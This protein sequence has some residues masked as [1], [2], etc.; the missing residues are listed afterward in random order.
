MH[1]GCQLTQKTRWHRSLKSFENSK[2]RLNQQGHTT[3]STPLNPY[4][5]LPKREKIICQVHRVRRLAPAPGEGTARPLRHHQ[6]P[7]TAKGD[8]ATRHLF[9]GI[10]FA[11]YALQD[12]HTTEVFSTRFPH[13]PQM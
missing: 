10:R 13:S 3:R 11:R 7:L 1:S 6:I 2:R 12:G 9:F 5:S 4:L 8:A